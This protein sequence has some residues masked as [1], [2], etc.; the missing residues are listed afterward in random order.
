MLNLIIGVIIVYFLTSLWETV[1]HWKILHADKASR[2][3]WRQVGGIFN[4]LRKAYFSH[5]TIH[6]TKTYRTNYFQQFESRKQKES[7]DSKL[8][9]HPEFRIKCNRYGLNISGFWENIV[10]VGVPLLNSVI[11][12]YILSPPF[13]WVGFII[14]VI[15][16]LLSKYLHPLLH[17]AYAS[18]S[19]NSII[20]KIIV[21]SNFFKFIQLYHF[22]HHQY[23]MCN[24]N[25]MPGGDYVL[26]IA[27]KFKNS[28][29]IGTG[30]YLPNILSITCASSRRAKGAR[31]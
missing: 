3:R 31:R 17:D 14:A 10:F 4:L 13:I 23:A 8:N 1:V 18:K 12:L 25:L 15:P 19:T 11:V 24:F 5:H 26:G 16:M 6:H 28:Q 29:D 7:L 2:L 20:L 21:N 27:R 22:I 9:P 30:C